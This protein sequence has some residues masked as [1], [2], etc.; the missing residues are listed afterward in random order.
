MGLFD[1]K[2]SADE[3]SRILGDS[4]ILSADFAVS[5]DDEIETGSDIDLSTFESEDSGEY[6]EV[7]VIAAF[8][9]DFSVLSNE[10]RYL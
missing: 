1:T 6:S 10:L 9:S 5:V 3:L 2:P 8:G 7:E 4:S